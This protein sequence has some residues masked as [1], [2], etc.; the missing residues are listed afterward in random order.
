LLTELDPE[1]P[2]LALGLCDLGMGFPEIRRVRLSIST[3]MR[4]TVCLSEQR[5]L[6][7]TA[8]TPTSSMRVLLTM[9]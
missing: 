3:S 4:W 9:W 6:H 2:D 1:D 5:R 8:N 7:A